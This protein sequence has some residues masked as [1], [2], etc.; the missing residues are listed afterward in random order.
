MHT[1]LP[2]VHLDII[3]VVFT[4]AIMSMAG[5]N[6]CKSVNSHVLPYLHEQLY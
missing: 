4:I 6:L 2:S 3:V 5:R 1:L